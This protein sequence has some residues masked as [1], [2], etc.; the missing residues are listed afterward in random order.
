MTELMHFWSIF[1]PKLCSRHEAR[2]GIWLRL[3][4]FNVYLHHRGLYQIQN[5]LNA[6]LYQI[7]NPF[8]E[9]YQYKIHASQGDVSNTKSNQCRASCTEY[10]Y[11]SSLGC[12]EYRIQ[13][14]PTEVNQIQNPLVTGGYTKYKIHSM[15]AAVSNTKSTQCRAVPNTNTT[16]QRA[17]RNIKSMNRSVPNTKSTHNRMAT[18]PKSTHRA[19]PNTKSTSFRATAK[20]AMRVRFT[21]CSNS[22]EDDIGQKHWLKIAIFY[23]DG[24]WE[25]LNYHCWLRPWLWCLWYAGGRISECA[26]SHELGSSVIRP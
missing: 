26:S 3:R 12:T 10:K 5:P 9:V 7:Q 21:F 8:T 1:P 24:R 18:K 14:P 6:G 22:R 25:N 23:L 15:Q 20:I 16:H 4:L 13:N 17:V 19:V 2:G 11:H